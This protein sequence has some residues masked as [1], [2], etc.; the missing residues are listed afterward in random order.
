ME[1]HL[2]T[3]GVAVNDFPKQFSAAFEK[4]TGDV[5]QERNKGQLTLRPSPCPCTS[6]VFLT[7]GMG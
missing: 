4:V 5:A 1:L 3:W 7:D 2:L 6:H